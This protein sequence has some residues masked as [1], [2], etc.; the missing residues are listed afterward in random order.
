MYQTKLR[1]QAL[2]SFQVTD[3]VGPKDRL[4]LPTLL[5]TA[6]SDFRELH[7]Q[8]TMY[9]TADSGGGQVGGTYVG[10][11]GGGQRAGSGEY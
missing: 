3:R 5:G 9:L 8:G 11:F 1:V 10:E 6:I 4:K 7:F 2:Q